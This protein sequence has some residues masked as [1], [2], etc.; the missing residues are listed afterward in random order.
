M[1]NQSFQLAGRMVFL[2]KIGIMELFQHCQITEQLNR[3][4]NTAQAAD[5]SP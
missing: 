1:Q 4:V 5:K 3:G 2:G